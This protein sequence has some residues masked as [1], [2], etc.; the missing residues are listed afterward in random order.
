MIETIVSRTT[1]DG[2]VDGFIAVDADGSFHLTNNC[3]MGGPGYGRD[4]SCRY[5]MSERVVTDG[6]KGVGPTIMAGL[7]IAQLSG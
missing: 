7:Q 3:E 4:G 1:Y 5:C 2:L 6:P